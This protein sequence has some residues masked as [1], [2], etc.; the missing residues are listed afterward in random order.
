MRKAGE[1]W[2]G[3]ST[4][5]RSKYEKLHEEDKKRY[6]KQLEELNNNGYFMMEDGTKSSDH[7]RKIKNKRNKI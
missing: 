6:E 1:V 3:M 5:E 4:K 2:S 7:Q